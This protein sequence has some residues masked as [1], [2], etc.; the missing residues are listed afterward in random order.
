MSKNY[1]DRLTK[2][3]LYKFCNFFW[4]LQMRKSLR[5]WN[6]DYFDRRVIILIFI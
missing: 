6:K 2:I 4:L 3:C 1:N 5:L